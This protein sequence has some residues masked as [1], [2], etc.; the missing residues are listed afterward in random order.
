MNN[1]YQ[2]KIRGFVSSKNQELFDVFAKEFSKTTEKFKDIKIYVTTTDIT[3]S[4]KFVPNIQPVGV[5]GNIAEKDLLRKELDDKAEIFLALND[6]LWFSKG[7]LEDIIR[8]LDE[9]FLAVAAGIANTNDKE[10]FNKSIEKTKDDLGHE[11]FIYLVCAAWTSQLF[12][13]IGLPDTNYAGTADDTDW[14]YRILINK[15]PFCSLRRIRVAHL[16][17]GITRGMNL[18]NKHDRDLALNSYFQKA[19]KSR[20]YF[21]EKHGYYA[22][23]V[24][25]RFMKNNQ[26]YRQFEYLQNV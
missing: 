26:Y 14:I 21:R 2:R 5:F 25:E 4:G 22:Y 15:V 9:G 8:K 16:N 17:M 3:V 20:K 19:N 7:W 23:K 24:T 13:T 1:I 11:N 12:K 18:K 6:D 10:F